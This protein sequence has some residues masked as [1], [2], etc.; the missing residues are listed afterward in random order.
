MTAK[1][2]IARPGHQDHSPHPRPPSNNKSSTSPALRA[3]VAS[4]LKHLPEVLGN[5][6]PTHT[7]K[8]KPN[9]TSR[10][11]FPTQSTQTIKTPQRTVDK[12][13]THAPNRPDP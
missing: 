5:A 1:E 12:H 10:S 8:I 13:Q 3:G 4:L 11:I 2:Q 9:Q 6:H 7:L